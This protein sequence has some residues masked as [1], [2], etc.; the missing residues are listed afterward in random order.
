M[1]EKQSKHLLFNLH[2]TPPLPTNNWIACWLVAINHFQPTT[3]LMA[4]IKDVCLLVGYVSWRSSIC[5]FRSKKPF[6]LESMRIYLS[7]IIQYLCFLTSQ[8]NTRKNKKVKQNS[9]KKERA[10]KNNDQ[11]LDT[12]YFAAAVVFAFVLYLLITTFILSQ[13]FL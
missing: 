5:S 11:H 2:R 6:L 9:K 13:P 8:I 12:I 3:S 4:I 7:F 1:N 10:H